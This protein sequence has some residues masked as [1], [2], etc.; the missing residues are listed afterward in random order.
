M[1][2]GVHVAKTDDRAL[3][4]KP[5]LADARRPV[6]LQHQ[7]HGTGRYAV[8]QLIKQR[9][10]LDAQLLGPLHLAQAEFL[11]K[12]ADHPEAAIN[13]HLGI[14]VIRNRRRVWRDQ[15]DGFQVRATRGVDGR[16]S[17]IGQTGRARL[18][19]AGTKY[20]TG[21]VGTGGNQ[22]QAFGNP[23]MAAGGCRDMAE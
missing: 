19:T 14:E 11:L 18:D 1:R 22:R 20:L 2:T 10:G 8:D 15:R 7:P 6:G 21:L 4:L 13:H 9:L 23:G 17:A 5:R 3:G 16:R 12:P